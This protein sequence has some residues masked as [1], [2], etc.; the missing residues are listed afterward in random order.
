[1]N[2]ARLITKRKVRITIKR[3]LNSILFI[4]IVD[5]LVRMVGMKAKR[6]KN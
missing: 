1:M 6:N 4:V 3:M 5:S 2:S